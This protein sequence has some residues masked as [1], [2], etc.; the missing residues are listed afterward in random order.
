MVYYQGTQQRNIMMLLHQTFK[1]LSILV[2]FYR[3][4]VLYRREGIC[5][6]YGTVS[7]VLKLK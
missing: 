6:H 5:I 4:G 7:A 1:S 3:L 2:D